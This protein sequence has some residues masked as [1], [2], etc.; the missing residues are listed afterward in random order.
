[1]APSMAAASAALRVIGPTWSRDWARGNTPARLTR[2]QVGFNPVM[3][4]MV[5]GKRIDP[6]VSVPSINVGTTNFPA[7][8]VTTDWNLLGAGTLQLGCETGHAT[9]ILGIRQPLVL[10]DQRL[11]LRRLF[12][13]P[14]Q[15]LYNRIECL[16]DHSLCA[17]L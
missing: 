2:P 4:L 1:M 3:P 5:E 15:H 13:S 12:G 7:V 16:N 14:R 10:A 17:S 6:S 8:N 11:L 9:G